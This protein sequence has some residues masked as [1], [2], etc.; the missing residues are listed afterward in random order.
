MS[1]RDSSLLSR[2]GH[3]AESGRGRWIRKGTSNGAA[4]TELSVVFSLLGVE[5]ASHSASSLLDQR[6]RDHEP[7]R[8]PR[9]ARHSPGPAAKV[10]F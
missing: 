10:A 2:R 1:S 6:R 4:N 8:T 9:D 3:V 5:S 7:G